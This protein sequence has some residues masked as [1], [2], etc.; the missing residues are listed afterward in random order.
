MPDSELGPIFA[1]RY[2][3]RSADIAAFPIAAMPE[4]PV[5]DEAAAQRWYDNHPDLYATPE[6]RR[7]KVV[8]VSPATVAP[9]ITV[10]DQE[11]QAAYE[12]HRGDYTTIA[13]R[14]ARGDLHHR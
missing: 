6:Y 11:L 2:E 14:S 12:E 5:P 4:P 10:S 3:K 8:V 7:V 1:S 13:K 9:E